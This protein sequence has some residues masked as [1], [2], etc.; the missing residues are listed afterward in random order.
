MK[1]INAGRIMFAA[2]LAFFIA[3][4]T[5]FGWNS[6]PINR[7]EE[8]MD[9]ISK[10]HLWLAVVVYTWPLVDLYVFAV[11]NMEEKKKDVE[12]GRKKG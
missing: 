4:N 6:E 5:W 11:E 3:Y 7:T 12:D 10:L 2:W 8:I 9:L 1:W